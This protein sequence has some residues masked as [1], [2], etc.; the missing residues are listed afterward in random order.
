MSA[1]GGQFPERLRAV[2]SSELERRLLNAAAREQPSRELSER[3]A[4]VIGV[5]P[6]VLWAAPNGGAGGGAA[7]PP[8]ASGSSALLPW[9]SG[10][11]LAV[12]V[13]GALVALRPGPVPVRAPVVVTSPQEA[14]PPEAPAPSPTAAAVV[15]AP[16]L[17]SEPTLRAPAP[18][19]RNRAE[20]PAGDLREQIVLLDAA[21][22]ALANGASE[23][24]LEL[25]QRYLAKYPVGSFRP[26]ATALRVD[27]LVKLGRNS[28][29][30]TLADRL[31]RD[32]DG[33]PLAERVKRATS[34]TRQ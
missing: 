11:A 28:E 34:S 1:S 13:G 15:E 21:R 10:A 3:M 12:A 31:A 20:A 26:E 32:E 23:R 22:A 30:R 16:S 7:A 14:A 8:T 25:L 17:P 24:A 5:A 29:A 9:L 27:A 6:P 18:Q 33:S 2:S 19:A 4:R